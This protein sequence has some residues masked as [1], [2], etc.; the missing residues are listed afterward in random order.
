[1]R[2]CV[3]MTP[4]ARTCGV[5]CRAW[6]HDKKFANSNMLS[7]KHK[8]KLNKCMKP[9]ANSLHYVAWICHQELCCP[10]LW[11]LSL[12][13]QV[14]PTTLPPQ[15]L[16]LT[17]NGKW[18]D[19]KRTYPDILSDKQNNLYMSNQHKCGAA[20]SIE[21]DSLYTKSLHHLSHTVTDHLSHTTSSHTIFD[22]WSFTHHFVTHHL[23]HTIFDTPSYTHHLSPHHLSHTQLCHKP[24]FLHLLLCLSFLPRPRCKI[25]WS[26]LE[27]VDLWGYAVP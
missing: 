2:R 12:W 13:I 16:G 18:K 17:L 22:T 19:L 20:S 9:V 3:E 21:K 4:T 10:L 5:N 24:F 26:L 8:S 25:C 15:Y 23:S 7:V 1:M 14:E 11:C 6:T 27:E